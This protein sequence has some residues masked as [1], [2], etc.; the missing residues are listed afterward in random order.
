MLKLRQKYDE[1][2]NRYTVNVLQCVFIG[3]IDLMTASFSIT[4]KS[5]F[6]KKTIWSALFLYEAVVTHGY[7]FL[8][9]EQ[10]PVRR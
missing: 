2:S 9:S 1:V 10:S 8:L 4:C 6:K 5:I 3:G 7:S